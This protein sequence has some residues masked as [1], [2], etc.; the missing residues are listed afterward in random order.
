MHVIYLYERT[1]THI[2]SLVYHL[3]FDRV[4]DKRLNDI[5]VPN[6]YHPS[7]LVEVN[8][9]RQ[10]NRL[11]WWYNNCTVAIKTHEKVC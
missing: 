6:S 1:R 4:D 3:R 10:S 11:A 7:D 9:M 8:G 5:Q 2:I